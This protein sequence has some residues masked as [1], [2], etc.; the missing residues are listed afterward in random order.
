[1]KRKI[2]NVKEKLIF[3]IGVLIYVLLLRL[4]DSTCIILSLFGFICPGCGMTR[5]LISVLKLDFAA[6]L[7]YH[8]LV[9]LMPLVIL[10]FLFDGRLF[11]KVADLTVIS[12]MVLSFLAVWVFRLAA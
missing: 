9:F 7:S 3:A 5:A 11:G 1:L 2:K 4:F 12:L 6:A 8:P 10:Y